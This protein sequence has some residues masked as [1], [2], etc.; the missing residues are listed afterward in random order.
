MDSNIPT[1]GIKVLYQHVDI[2]NTAG[3]EAYILHN[4]SPFRCTWFKNDTNVKYVSEVEIHPED[5]LVV[6]EVYGS[7]NL[8]ETQIK[9]EQT[10][11][12]KKKRP[13][14]LNDHENIKHLIKTKCNKVVFNQNCYN[15]FINSDI[16]ATDINSL[17]LEDDVKAA[18]V[19]SKDSH[20]Y[21]KYAFPQLKVFRVRNSI[22]QEIF[23]Y[24]GNKKMQFAY[25]S[26]KNLHDAQQVISIIR[27]K[28]IIKDFEIIPIHNLNEEG[29]AQ[30]LKDSL[31]FLSFGYPEGFSLPPAEAMLCGS[32]VI[33]YH[34]WGGKEYF[35]S[36]YCFPVEAGEIISYCKKI[37]EAV[38]IFR[39]NPGKIMKMGKEASDY[40]KTNYTKEN[41]RK[42]VLN[43]WSNII[44]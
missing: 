10:P 5:Y 30:V 9:S 1:G 14:P 16:H 42:D 4:Q 32:V 39:S 25:M 38:S 19:V 29:V 13:T 44:L 6:P 18:I 2:L 11:F 41:E 33:G 31:F 7:I 21:L 20:Q 26:R 27:L 15:S 22:N 24:S 43:I 17:Y 40:I 8:E 37:E 36:S 28:S 3:F 34:G 35:N 12:W 23:S